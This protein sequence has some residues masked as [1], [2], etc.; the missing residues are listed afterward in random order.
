MFEIVV[1]DDFKTATYQYTIKGDFSV[2]VKNYTPEAYAVT[3]KTEHFQFTNKMAISYEW[4]A[5]CNIPSMLGRQLRGE[6]LGAF[7]P[8]KSAD[9]LEAGLRYM[10][11]TMNDAGFTCGLVHG[12]VLSTLDDAVNK[13]TYFDYQK[14]MLGKIKQTGGLGELIT[15]G[16]KFVPV[17]YS[18]GT[19]SQPTEFAR[20]AREF[21]QSD[22]FFTIVTC[23]VTGGRK[24]LR[25]AIMSL[26]DHH[27]WTREEIADWLETLDVDINMKP[28]EEAN[29]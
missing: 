3:F 11:G 8:L 15:P 1:F 10:A 16:S 20:K 12:Q 7:G 27:G 23:P 6:F 19:L 22:V 24:H 17:G 5:D 9:A 26:N 28:K 4:A 13:M 18:S 14:E 29:V 2:P 21:S 25:S